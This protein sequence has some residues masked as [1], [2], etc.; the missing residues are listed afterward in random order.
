[1]KG[2]AQVRGSER[3]ND[4][5]VEEARKEGGGREERKSPVKRELRRKEQGT[6]RY[7]GAEER[8]EE[9]EKICRKEEQKWVTDRKWF[10]A[11][12]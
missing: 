2:K 8:E 1:M 9:R 4:V 11:E 10:V 6:G 7:A 5:N 3:G 12:G